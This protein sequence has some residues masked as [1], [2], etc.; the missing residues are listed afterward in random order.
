[1]IVYTKK[2][3]EKARELGLDERKAG[4]RAMLGGKPLEDCTKDVIRGWIERGYAQ[5]VADDD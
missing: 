3:E 4:Q 1:M 2:A 5:E